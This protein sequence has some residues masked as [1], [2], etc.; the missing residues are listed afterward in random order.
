MREAGTAHTQSR[1]E[2]GSASVRDVLITP[3]GSPGAATH[4]GKHYIKLQAIV[5]SPRF[6]QWTQ[7]ERSIAATEVFEGHDHARM[8]HPRLQVK[9]G[10]LINA[11]MFDRFCHALDNLSE[12]G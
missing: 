1:G 6:V 11:A 2:D 12:A 9:R 8:D 3:R 5:I 10:K 4:V 7:G